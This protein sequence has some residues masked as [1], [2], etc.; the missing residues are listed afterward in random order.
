MCHINGK[1]RVIN[2][3]KRKTFL[4][5]FVPHNNYYPLQLILNLLMD[6]FCFHGTG[7]TMNTGITSMSFTTAKLCPPHVPVHGNTA[8]NKNKR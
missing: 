2:P 5:Y 4:T 8:Q 1:E 3:T 7:S 6:S